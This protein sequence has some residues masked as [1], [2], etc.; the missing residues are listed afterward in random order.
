VLIS[1]SVGTAPV[2]FDLRHLNTMA[3]TAQPQR[4]NAMNGRTVG[5]QGLA[6]SILPWFELVDSRGSA[7]SR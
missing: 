1:S 6:A 2:I 3:V 5:H 7:A 4:P